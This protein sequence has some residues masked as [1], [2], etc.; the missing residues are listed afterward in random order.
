MGS[1]VRGGGEEAGEGS[2]T[3]NTWE[4][5]GRGLKGEGL[6]GAGSKGGGPEG[7]G[8]EGWGPDGWEA[9]KIGAFFFA[10][11]PPS[12]SFFFSLSGGSF[13]GILVVFEAPG[14]SNV[15]VWSSRAVV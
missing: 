14:R 3:W 7:G 13:R 6:E 12:F 10:T 2:Q 15:H 4:L 11:L 9:Q 8:A 5:Q 1:K